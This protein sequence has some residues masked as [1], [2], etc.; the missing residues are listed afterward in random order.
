MDDQQIS[1]KQAL[2][3]D[4]AEALHGQRDLLQDLFAEAL[5]DFAMDR[6]IRE[7]LETEVA[8]REMVFGSLRDEP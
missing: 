2:K 8:S 7:G 6:A 1:L 3:D 4:L 5:E